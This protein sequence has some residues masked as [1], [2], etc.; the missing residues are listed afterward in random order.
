MDIHQI[1]ERLGG[2]K[3]VGRACGV[4]RQA[5]CQWDAIPPRFVLTLAAGGIV[6]PH[7][8]RPDFYPHPLDGRRVTE[9]EKAKAPRRAKIVKRARA[10]G[11][12][13]RRR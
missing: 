12:G 3:N 11:S 2:P 13:K 10:N 9:P 8:M 1:I 7:E 4:T 5:V 6:T